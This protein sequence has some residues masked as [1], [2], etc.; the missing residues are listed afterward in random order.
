MQSR[1]RVSVTRMLTN[2]IA[3]QEWRERERERERER[4]REGERESHCA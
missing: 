3:S 2:S 1:R 4:K